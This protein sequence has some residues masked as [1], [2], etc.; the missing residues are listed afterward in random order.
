[1]ELHRVHF[2]GCAEEE[3]TLEEE[4]QPKLMVC[5]AHR[6]EWELSKKVTKQSKIT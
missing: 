1:M 2:T 3:V 6:E 5:V 4:G